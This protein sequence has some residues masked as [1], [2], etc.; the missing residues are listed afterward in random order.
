MLRHFET[1]AQECHLFDPFDITHHGHTGNHHEKAQEPIATE[2]TE[3]PT[4][5]PAPAPEFPH[6]PKGHFVLKGVKLENCSACKR[7]AVV[8]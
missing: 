8:V 2:S 1:V 6:C 4:P 7:E 5:A 3:E